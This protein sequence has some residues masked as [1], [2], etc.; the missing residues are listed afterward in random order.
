MNNYLFYLITSFLSLSICANSQSLNN[1]V[2]NSKSKAYALLDLGF[3]AKL[4]HINSE[5]SNTVVK[6]EAVKKSPRSLDEIIAK[7]KNKKTEKLTNVANLTK[8]YL[9]AGCFLNINNAQR[10]VSRLN[11]QGH[12]SK[13][14][15]QNDRGLHMV[16]FGSYTSKSDAIR[17]QQNLST[18]GV[19]TWIKTN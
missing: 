5:G 4:L 14:L 18:K 13:I 6:K 1:Q 12:S 15:E 16:A 10:L 17:D 3:S 7:S 2:V 19:S 9:V 11:D 8:Y